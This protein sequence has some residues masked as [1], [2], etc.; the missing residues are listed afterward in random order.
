[1]NHPVIAR[2]CAVFYVGASDLIGPS[3]QRYICEARN[4]A[5][6]VLRNDYHLTVDRIGKLL[7]RRDHTTILHGIKQCDALMYLDPRYTQ[8]VRRVME[9]K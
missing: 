7:G 4:A 3:R 5:A 1:M 9:V 8:R 2:T 6:W